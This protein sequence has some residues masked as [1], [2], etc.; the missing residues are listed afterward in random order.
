MPKLV[1][2]PPK[3]YSARGEEFLRKPKQIDQH[4]Q[5]TLCTRNIS[6]CT[7]EFFEPT[8]RYGRSSHAMDAIL[9]ELFETM[10]EWATGATEYSAMPMKRRVGAEPS[11]LFLN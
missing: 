6:T 2:R 4:S 9:I 3:V 11:L 7:N 8:W 5:P 1:R 10:A